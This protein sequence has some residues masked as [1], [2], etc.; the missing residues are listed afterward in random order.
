MRHVWHLELTPARERMLSAYFEYCRH[1]I[2]SRLNESL[3]FIDLVKRNTTKTKKA[4]R[5]RDE[6]SVRNAKGGQQS[7]W[8]SSNGGD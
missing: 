7:I 4:L 8:R 2:G 6:H 1:E 3:F 5:C